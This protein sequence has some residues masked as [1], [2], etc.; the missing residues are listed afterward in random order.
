MT[1]TVT[2]AIAITSTST[3]TRT[4]TGTS[5]STIVR[6]NHTCLL[7]TCQ[8]S[9]VTDTCPLPSCL[10]ADHQFTHLTVTHHLTT[11]LPSDQL[12]AIYYQAPHTRY[13]LP[14]AY[15]LRPEQ[16]LFL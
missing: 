4:G 6:A 11:Y 10:S 8:L 16:A 2:T 13:L 1:V 3:S 5:A 7:G 9:T 15:R 14:T 12:P